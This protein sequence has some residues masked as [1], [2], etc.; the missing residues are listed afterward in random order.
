[1]D[2]IEM[3]GATVEEAL[4][5][6]LTQLGRREEE[7]EVEVLSKGSR[8]F[9]GI[10]A[11]PASI[12]VKVKEGGVLPPEAIGRATDFLVQ[13]VKL[14]GMDVEVEAKHF[15]SE[16]YLEIDQGAGGILI[17]RHGTTL[18]ALS[19]LMERIVNKNE[20]AR[21]KVFVDVAGYLERKRRSLVTMAQEMA[22]EVKATGRESACGPMSAFERK[23]I[24]TTLHG[25]KDVK[26]FSR[27]EG[28]ERRVIIAPPGADSG[29]ADP[30]PEASAGAPS[31]GDQRG[32]FDR[33][34][35]G[36]GGRGSRGDFG[37]DGRRRGR[38]RGR[39]GPSGGDFQGGG[40]AEPLP[41]AEDSGNQ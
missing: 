20:D 2:T 24:H 39:R 41:P 32:R 26:T 38:R 11:K 35:E 3:E 40:G 19:T 8:G 17:G 25:D 30:S 16:L 22:V 23:V 34:G 4:A 33:P 5:A 15:G 18:A 12:K 21:V 37:G 14:M 31:E 10:G 9:L 28:A 7:V 27:G 1:M 36:R 29:S 13:V 6:A